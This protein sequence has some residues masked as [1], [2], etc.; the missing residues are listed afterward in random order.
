[1]T[2]STY[3]DAYP[4]SFSRDNVPASHPG[5]V[6]AEAAYES[7][8]ALKDY[9]KTLLTTSR[10]L[11]ALLLAAL[12]SAL[13]VVANQL[14]DTWADGHLL[15]AWTLMWAIVFASIGLLAPVVKNAVS[16]GLATAIVLERRR[17]TARSEAAFL[18]TAQA[19]PRV[20][21]ELQAAILR[22]E[23]QT[24]KVAVEARALSV[25]A[26]PAVV[27]RPPAALGHLRYI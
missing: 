7:F 15:A 25:D 21:A 10:G 9:V 11:S 26:A 5:V 17:A 3:P 13:V 1:M 6:R 24:G 22:H 23:A 4:L 14:I 2:R 12:V 8:V 18:A 19:D 16:W 27:R 20:M